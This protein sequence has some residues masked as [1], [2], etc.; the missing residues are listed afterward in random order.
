[1]ADVRLTDN[2]DMSTELDPFT[3]AVAGVIARLKSQRD[4]YREM[5]SVAVNK[6]AELTKENGELRQR[7]VRSHQHGLSQ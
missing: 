1:M 6:V 5:H 3:S 4:M 2:V 7:L